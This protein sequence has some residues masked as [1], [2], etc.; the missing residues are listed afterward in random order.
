[1]SS[2]ELFIILTIIESVMIMIRST[3][4][5]HIHILCTPRTCISFF[6]VIRPLFEE[7]CTI[8]SNIYGG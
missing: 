3:Q 4:N 6:Y 8:Y 7:K 1:M 2:A 5:M